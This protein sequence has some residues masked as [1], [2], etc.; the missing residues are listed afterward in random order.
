MQ[1]IKSSRWFCSSKG[2]WPDPL[3]SLPVD[4]GRQSGSSDAGFDIP[5]KDAITVPAGE[6]RVFLLEIYLP[7]ETRKQATT[8]VT[9]FRTDQDETEDLTITVNPYSFDLPRVPSFATA[10]K[11]PSGR[12]S[13]THEKLSQGAFDP[14]ELQLAYFE[15]MAEHRISAYS[16]GYNRIQ[17]VRSDNGELQFDWSEYEQL[18]GGLLD[19]TLFPELP[20]ATSARV[21][22]PAENLDRDEMIQFYREF[23][24]RA[25]GNGWLDRMFYYLPD[26][27]MRREYPEV[28]EIATLIREADPGIRTLATEPFTKHLAGYVD[29]WCPDIPVIGDSI[30]FLPLAFGPPKNVYLDRQWNPRPDRY[31]QRWSEGETAWFY[32]CT[33]AQYLDYPNLFIDSEAAYHRVIPWLAFRH[34]FS[35]LLY[36]DVLRSYVKDNDPWRSQYQFR[37]NGDGNLFYPG[38][39]EL[40]NVDSHKP[41]P[42]LRLKLLREGIEDYEYLS[43]YVALCGQAEADEMAALIA[44]KSLHWEHEMSALQAVRNRIAATIE[45]K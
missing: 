33:S 19:G 26:E 16:P 4:S 39:P 30:R 43:L 9:G 10:F 2:R 21:P 31:R 40:P 38:V 36:Y 3:T 35:G 42:S 6:N 5:L 1:I 24:A 12:I 23:A 20:P 32:T 18:T 15:C 8:I 11:M 45:A 34:G 28:R 22:L 7:P 44:R 37:S 17:S 41:V 13:K 29:I 14:A 25:R 27:P